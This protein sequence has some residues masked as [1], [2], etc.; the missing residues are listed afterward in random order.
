MFVVWF[1]AQYGFDLLIFQRFHD[2]LFLLELFEARVSDMA[3]F[4]EPREEGIK[5][6]D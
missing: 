2:P 5:R 6:L 4:T 3:F 1:P